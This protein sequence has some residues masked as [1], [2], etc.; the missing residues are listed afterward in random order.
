MAALPD[1]PK[2]TGE[3]ALRDVDLGPDADGDHPSSEALLAYTSAGM[4]LVKAY[5]THGHLAASLD[6]LGS[7]APDDPALHPEYL[8]LSEEAMQAVPASAKWSTA[9]TCCWCSAC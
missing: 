5:R 2:T 8:G 1:K 4:S 9:I 6:P 7:A 3:F